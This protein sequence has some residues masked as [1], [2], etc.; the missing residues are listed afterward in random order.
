MTTSAL[1]DAAPLAPRE[2]RFALRLSVVEGMLATV[3]T[4]LTLSPFLTGY[5]L[6]LGAS[7]QYV[8][9][10][11][12]LLA[13]VRVSQLGA[14]YLI[15]WAGRRRPLACWLLGLGR[16]LWVALGLLAF[17]PWPGDARL[18][19]FLVA[20]T[21]AAG[22]IELGL[23][24]WSDWMVD[25]VPE[26]H[27][28]RYFGLRNTAMATL[29]MGVLW[30]GGG[31]LDLQR[32]AGQEALGFGAL[33]AVAGGAA[34]LAQLALTAQ[35][36]PRR[37]FLPPE[38][39]LLARPFAAPGPYR[40]FLAFAALWF[41]CATLSGPFYTV[42]A[43]NELRF[44][45]GFIATYSNAATAIAL[46]TQ[47]LWGRL[48]DRAGPV[49]VLRLCIAGVVLLPALWLGMTPTLT[50]PIW[51]DMIATGLFWPGV[52]LGL[53]MALFRVA[54]ADH[55]AVYLGA[56]AALTGAMVALAAALGSGVLALF[57]RLV[58]PETGWNAYQVLF[59]LTSTGR[60]C[61]WLVLMRLRLG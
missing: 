23:N 3:F 60:L 46:L 5:A 13:L 25:L 38:Q 53:A 21:L 33:F 43:L 45:Y 49:Y 54:P 47:P 26:S 1:G 41:L 20:L 27:R 6:L 61:A 57:A 32:A 10:L 35:P 52:N 22:L 16:Y 40:R 4:T 39:G 34:L 29:G 9:L 59:L 11:E 50:W 56:F 51:L 15:G 44:S 7:P 36:E 48:I 19:L 58:G 31:Y 17:L 30:L 37:R 8:G 28:G 42:Y 12:A 2:L 18:A 14:I 24:V 55:R